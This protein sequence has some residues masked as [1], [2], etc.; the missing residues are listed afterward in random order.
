MKKTLFLI[1]TLFFISA[2]RP[3]SAPDETAKNELKKLNAEIVSLYQQKKY[4][5]AAVLAHKSVLST[6]QLFG[7]EHLETALAWRNLGYVQLAKNDTKAAENT[8]EKAFEIFKNYPQLDK[9]NS[10]NLAEMLESLAFIKYQKRVDSAENL[11]ETALTWREKTDGADSL[12]TAKSLSALANISY[13]KRDYKKSSL[14]FQRL[15]EILSKNLGNADSETTLAFHRTECSYRKAGME[16]DFEAV[17]VKFNAINKLPAT[18]IQPKTINGG[19]VNGKATYLAKPPYPAAARQAL[20]EGKVEV[21]VLI[22]EQG[23]VLFACAQKA[24]HPTL[25][26]GAEAAAY[27]SKFQP[28]ILDGT[29]IRVSGILV[30]IFSRR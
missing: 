30:Y 1:I 18:P 7:R 4:D 6:E 29:P 5:E 21:Q 14:L 27:Q 22:S 19:M 20:A 8:L 12:K 23:E 16:A 26:E 24:A 25:V 3:Q 13:W 15:L 9:K 10:A 28:T 17:K 11:Y 2:V